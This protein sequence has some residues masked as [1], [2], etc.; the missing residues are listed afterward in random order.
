MNVILEIDGERHRLVRDEVQSLGANY[1]ETKCSI[2][3]FCNENCTVC[4]CCIA[5]GNG[6]VY[7]HYE[8]EES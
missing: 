6:G 8:K 7:H 3:E 1:C 4:P 2:R 5:N